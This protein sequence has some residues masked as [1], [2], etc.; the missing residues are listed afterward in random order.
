MTV[1]WEEDTPVSVKIAGRELEDDHVYRVATIDYLSDRS[2]SDI[3]E[4]RRTD[5]LQRDV[6]AEYIQEKGK[7]SPVLDGRTRLAD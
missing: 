2:F 7:I 6:V 5:L 3:D 4:V 1:V